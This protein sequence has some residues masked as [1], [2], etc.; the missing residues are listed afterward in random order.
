ME[1]HQTPIR[2]SKNILFLLDQFKFMMH[3][4]IDQMWLVRFG[5]EWLHMSSISF[6]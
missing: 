4:L 1:E 2:N 3:G 5:A 6:P